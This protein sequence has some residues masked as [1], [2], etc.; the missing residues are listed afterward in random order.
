MRQEKPEIY[1]RQS[2]GGSVTVWAAFG[3]NGASDIV[4]IDSR[5]NA[6]KYQKLL[7][8]AM[9]PCITDICG[10]DAIFQQDNAPCH[11]AKS[12]KLWFKSKKINLMEWPSKSTDLNPIENLWGIL[13]RTVYDNHRQFASIQ[14]LKS[15]IIDAWFNVG[16]EVHQKLIE[17]MPNRVYEVISRNGASTH[18]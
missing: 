6:E 2:G 10:P 15:A 11:A 13:V 18:Y 3:Y 7:D 17:S 14:E 12:T 5:L 16:P 9:L 1:S 8:S 4:F